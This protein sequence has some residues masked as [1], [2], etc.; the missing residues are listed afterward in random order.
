MAELLH[1][2]LSALRVHDDLAGRPV[3][4][5]EVIPALEG[6]HAAEAFD[7]DLEVDHG[8]MEVGRRRDDGAAW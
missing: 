4:D 1:R 7:A 5:E 2:Q 3:D 8:R 6:E